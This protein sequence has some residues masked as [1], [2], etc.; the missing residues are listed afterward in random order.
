MAEGARL[1]SVY[2]L[3]AYRGFESLSLRQNNKPPFGGFLLAREGEKPRR[4]R[5]ERFSA[6][7]RRSET[8]AT[9]RAKAKPDSSLSAKITNPLS[10]VF[11][12]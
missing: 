6:R 3:T 2:A 7:Q 12:G 5:A 11:I 4:V 9:R 8:T 1:E 10:G